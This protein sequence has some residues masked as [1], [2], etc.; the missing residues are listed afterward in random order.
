MTN[1]ATGKSIIT[2]IETILT[3]LGWELEDLSTLKSDLSGYSGTPACMLI[4]TGIDFEENF[5][6]TPKYNELSFTIIV[7]FKYDNP[8]SARDKAI[9]FAYA[10]REGI[11]T[12][13]LNVGDL[14]DSQYVSGVRHD[15]VAFEYTAPI[16]V[17][18]YDLVIRHREI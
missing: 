16:A 9:D 15:V 14:E 3:T 1:A 12:E 2:N 6:E 11:K 8:A 4:L 10:I 5:G 7:A 18:N 17:I 13:F